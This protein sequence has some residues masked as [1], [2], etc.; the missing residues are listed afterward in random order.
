[1]TGLIRVRSD[2]T[3]L[4]AILAHTACAQDNFPVENVDHVRIISLSIPTVAC[5]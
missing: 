3:V 5:R 2:L 1:M 4:V